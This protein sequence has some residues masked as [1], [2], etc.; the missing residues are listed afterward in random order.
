MGGTTA[1]IWSTYDGFDY[2]FQ[3]DYGRMWKYLVQCYAEVARSNPDMK[4]SLE[5]KPYEPRQFYFINDIGTTLLAVLEADCDNLG[6]TLDFA[7]MLMKKENPA[8]SLALAAERG[9]LFG[10]HLNDGYGSH[11]DGL[12][13]GSVSLLQ[14]LEF[15]YYM[16]RYEYNGV[17]FF[18]TFPLREDPVKELELN[19]RVFNRISDWIDNIGMERLADLVAQQDALK[20]Q[21]MLVLEGLLK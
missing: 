17:I 8:Y 5:Y 18:D 13:L 6:I 19:I 21:E 11:D 10:F 14:T 15:I 9:K 3:A 20:V 16:K 4:I 2:P 1:T 7:H 12:L